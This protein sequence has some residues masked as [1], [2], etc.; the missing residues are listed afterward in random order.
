VRA[1]H[2][3]TA[4]TLPWVL[5]AYQFTFRPESSEDEGHGDPQR[6]FDEAVH[7]DEPGCC[8]AARFTQEKPKTGDSCLAR[9]ISASDVPRLPSVLFY[10]S[11]LHPAVCATALFTRQL[12]SSC[13]VI[14]VSQS[15]QDPF[16]PS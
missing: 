14:P 13:G 4:Q 1:A 7:C 8:T 9:V 12:A 11:T 10:S 15:H 16:A 5:A 3:L 6:D 2:T